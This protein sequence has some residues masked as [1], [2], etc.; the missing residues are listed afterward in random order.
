MVRQVI[1]HFLSRTWS[2]L[3]YFRVIDKGI[4]DEESLIRRIEK[5]ILENLSSGDG[6]PAGQVF[7][8]SCLFYQ[9]IWFLLTL[10][11]DVVNVNFLFF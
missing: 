5:D 6:R 9:Y 8:S 10:L 7:A 3:H 4:L 11:Q 2:L 1:C